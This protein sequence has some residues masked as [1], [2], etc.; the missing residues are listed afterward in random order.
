MPDIS[1]MFMDYLM[2]SAARAREQLAER[3]F[4]ESPLHS[5]LTDNHAWYLSN[6]ATEAQTISYSGT[7]FNYASWDEADGVTYTQF[8]PLAPEVQRLHEEQCDP[9]WKD[10]I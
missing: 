8:I 10:L 4:T 1:P 3:V 5:Y 6:T 2:R 7:E 9:I